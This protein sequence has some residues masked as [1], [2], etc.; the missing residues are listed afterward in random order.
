MF[1]QET[2]C[3]EKGGG[4]YS[5]KLRSGSL[6]LINPYLYL[7]QIMWVVFFFCRAI[8]SPQALNK[9]SHF[10]FDLTRKEK[11]APNMF[12]SSLLCLLASLGA[13]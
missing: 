9:I 3:Y 13:L 2:A 8:F 12:I 7:E 1:L 4:D 6:K 11:K 10:A 5:A